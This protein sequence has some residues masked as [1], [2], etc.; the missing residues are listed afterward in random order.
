LAKIE[1]V[2]EIKTDTSA[3]SCEFRVTKDVADLKAKLDEFAKTNEHLAEWT[4]A[5]DS[6]IQ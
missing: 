3:T 1:G 6:E 4:F 5:K 2:S